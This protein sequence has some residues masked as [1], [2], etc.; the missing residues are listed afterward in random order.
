MKKGYSCFWRNS[1]ELLFLAPGFLGVSFFVLIPFCDV[2]RRSFYTALS[3]EF[4]GIKNYVSVFQNAAFK[5]AAANSLRFTAVCLPLLLVISLIL[6]LLMYQHVR[7]ERLKSLYLLP[8]AVP[9][10][11][12][13]F[14]WQMIFARQGFIN[15]WLESHVNFMGENTAFWILAG[16]YLWKNLGYTLVL[17]LAGL[18]AIPTDMLEAAKVDGASRRQSFFGIILPNLKGSMYTITVLSFLNSFKVFREAYLVSGSYPQERIYLIQHLFQNWY[19]GLEL[20]KLS[21]GAVLTA[22]A[23]G[24]VAILLQKIWE[25]EDEYDK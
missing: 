9:A 3:G 7:L 25:K 24:S 17:W 19:T 4:T 20:D 1:K 18:K 14:V 12:V 11:T 23:L 6:A 15:I 16:S 21:A 2:I 22:F 8:M 13:V 5:L 10:A